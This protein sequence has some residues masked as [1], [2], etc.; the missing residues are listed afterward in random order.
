[1][2][3]ELIMSIAI[4]IVCATCADCSIAI[5]RTLCTISIIALIGIVAFI[6]AAI[7]HDNPQL[8]GRIIVWVCLGMIYLAIAFYTKW[9]DDRAQQ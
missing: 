2:P 7:A 9:R 5:G 3:A 4:L 1:M 8:F 6:T